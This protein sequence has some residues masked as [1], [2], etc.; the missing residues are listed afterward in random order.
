MNCL[1]LPSYSEGFPSVLLEAACFELP[2][3]ATRVSGCVDAVAENQTG[4][5]IEP[6]DERAL[7]NCIMRVLKETHTVNEMGR[8]A[9]LRA[10]AEFSQESLWSQ[11]AHLYASL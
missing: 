4:W 10:V 6:R 7:A 9:R 11:Y 8:N 1:V 2:V 5:L 3:I